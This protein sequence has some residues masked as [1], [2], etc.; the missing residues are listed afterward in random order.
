MEDHLRK[1]VF[2]YVPLLFVS[3]FWFLNENESEPS[4]NIRMAWVS[5]AYTKGFS[6]MTLDDDAVYA[7]ENAESGLNGGFNLVKVNAGTGTVEW[8]SEPFPVVLL[9]PPII[10]KDYVYTFVD[11]NFIYCFNKNNGIIAAIVQVQETEPEAKIL[12]NVVAYGDYLYFGYYFAK[13]Y[14]H[15][16]YQYKHGGLMRFDIKTIDKSGSHTTQLKPG[17]FLWQLES[18]HGFGGAVVVEDNIVYYHTNTGYSNI[19]IKVLAINANTKEILWSKEIDSKECY[20]GV[21]NHG[22]V[23]QGNV[24]YFLALDSHTA[25][26]KYTGQEIFHI[27]FLKMAPKDMTA[28]GS[29]SQQALYYNGRFYYTNPDS[30]HSDSAPDYRNIHCI[31]ANTGIKVWNDVPPTPCE[32]LGTN[33]IIA[34]GRMYVPYGHGMRVYNPDN[35]HLIGVDKSFSGD[36]T[37]GTNILYKDTMITFQRREGKYT[38]K[39]YIVAI[40]VSK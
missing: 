19:P 31:D 9:T 37:F 35:G 39:K 40:G 1:L 24:L 3:C 26:N 15:T 22:L 17:E 28:F 12:D 7:Y 34:N 38:D 21:Q 13:D 10:I 14:D 29:W 27:S 33:P 8:R 30:A 32:A 18:G 4:Y 36:G 23:L 20:G 6:E 2:L 11:K 25:Y 16:M 5:N